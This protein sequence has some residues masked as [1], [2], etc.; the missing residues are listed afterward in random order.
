[1][2]NAILFPQNSGLVGNRA[3]FEKESV[4][5]THEFRP[6]LWWHQWPKAHDANTEQAVTIAKTKDF[7]NINVPPS[8]R[9]RHSAAD[10]I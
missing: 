4:Y 9:T 7:L 3:K 1:M 6:S 2:L 10:T 8:G 5:D